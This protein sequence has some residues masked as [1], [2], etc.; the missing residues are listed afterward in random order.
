MCFGT[1]NV[2][3][4]VDGLT[5]KEGSHTCQRECGTCL[6]RFERLISVDVEASRQKAVDPATSGP[7][8]R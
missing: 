8:T 7:S 5:D 2:G 1:E 3:T 6:R 4:M